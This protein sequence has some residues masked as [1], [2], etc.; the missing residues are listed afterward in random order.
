LQRDHS[1]TI[2]VLTSE[3]RGTKW[4]ELQLVA[5]IDYARMNRSGPAISDSPA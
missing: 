4:A 2:K 5:E 3:R 1:A